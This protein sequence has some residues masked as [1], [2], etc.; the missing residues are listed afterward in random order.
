MARTEDNAVTSS[1]RIAQVFPKLVGKKTH[2]TWMVYRGMLKYMINYTLYLAHYDA[3][4]NINDDAKKCTHLVSQ[5]ILYSFTIHLRVG[6][7]TLR[8]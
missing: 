5:T 2:A 8:I 7:K 4:F 1:I 3:H 6:R